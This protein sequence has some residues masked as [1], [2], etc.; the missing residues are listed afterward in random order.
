MP[1]APADLLKTTLDL[2]LWAPCYLTLATLVLA[3]AGVTILFLRLGRTGGAALATLL[4]I[5]WL[6]WPIWLSPA[7][8]G[9]RGERVASWLV[10]THPI[11]AANS[12][13]RPRLGYWAEQGM[14]YHW[15]SLQD[16]VAYA[17]P[18]NVLKCLALHAG[19]AFLC[20]TLV[21]AIPALGCL[22]EEPIPSVEN[23][24]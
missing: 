10:P 2:G 12:V 24:K 17:L 18:E 9:T 20:V 5:A 22:K 1:K 7:L 11:F 13:L 3:I 8:H 16:D 21:K 6:I 19:I 23:T 14:A 15:T 4:A